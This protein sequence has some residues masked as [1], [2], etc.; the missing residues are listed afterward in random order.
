MEKHTFYRQKGRCPI[1]CLFPFIFMSTTLTQLNYAKIERDIIA[2]IARG[3]E[4]LKAAYTRQVLRTNW[5]VGRYLKETL[6]L[7]GRPSANNARMIRRLAK[8]FGRPG[9]Y[10]YSL[11]KFYRLYPELPVD[12]PL[13]WSHYAVLLRIDD[14]ATRQRYRRLAVRKKISGRFL[15]GLIANDKAAAAA[16]SSRTK[17]HG[18]ALIPLTRGK[19][20]HY[21][22]TA[23]VDARS[24][25]GTATLDVGFETFRDIPLSKRSKLHVGYMVRTVKTAGTIKGVGDAPARPGNV[26]IFTA[27]IANDNN[28]RLYTYVATVERVVDGD[29]LI[30][31]IDLGLK[32]KTRR[33]LRL[34]GIDCPELT[35][36][37]GRY[38][39]GYVKK[40]LDKQEFIIIKTYKDDK[41]GRMLADVFY[42]NSQCSVEP[43]PARNRG[44][45]PLRAETEEEI[46]VEKGT[47]LNQQLLDEKLAEIWR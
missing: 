20:Y 14:P 46:V 5:E 24:N 16:G 31:M 37:R 27:R 6:P 41:Y 42:K 33:K 4:N 32:T 21:K 23:P 43:P 3:S 39:R 2:I 10:F 12:G 38:V 1:Y 40:L 47:Y 18:R 25:T 29:T 28:A 9:Y 8:K 26:A 7:D 45:Q 13:T 34:R 44:G 35:T 30:V 15:C 19:L 11:I 36:E 17:T 22:V